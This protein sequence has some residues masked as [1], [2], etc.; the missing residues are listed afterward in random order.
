M[1][2]FFFCTYHI[3]FWVI[4]AIHLPWLSRIKYTFLG[5]NIY[6][7][8]NYQSCIHTNIFLPFFHMILGPWVT[9][10]L[11][12]QSIECQRNRWS[13]KLTPNGSTRRP[14]VMN[15]TRKMRQM[16]TIKL[17]MKPKYKLFCI[18]LTLKLIN[19]LQNLCL[20][21]SRL[22]QLALQ[23]HQELLR[24]WLLNSSNT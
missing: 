13:F 21:L 5:I 10:I 20:S 12:M 6:I 18:Y 11:T 17:K 7:L 15:V 16:M 1:C 19:K 9:G 4:I 23:E 8:T 14:H 2:V 3:N 24:A 22:A